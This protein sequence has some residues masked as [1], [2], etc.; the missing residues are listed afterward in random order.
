MLDLCP[1]PHTYTHTA[2]LLSAICLN[3]HITQIAEGGKGPDM[4]FLSLHLKKR[5]KKN[6]S[7]ILQWSARSGTKILLS[8]LLSNLCHD[9]D[10][11][12]IY[13][14]LLLFQASKT[15]QMWE[16]GHSL[17]TSVILWHFSRRSIITSSTAPWEKTSKCSKSCSCDPGVVV[18]LVQV[19]SAKVGASPPETS[20]TN[21]GGPSICLR[22]GHIVSRPPQACFTW[23][24]RGGP[25]ADFSCQHSLLNGLRC[26]HWALMGK[27]KSDCVY[28]GAR[29]WELA[30]R[31]CVCR[32]S[33][34]MWHQPI[35][36]C[37]SVSQRLK[38]N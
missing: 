21:S 15:V 19:R 28:S 22:M 38:H 6:I 31:V 12:S 17:L 7:N 10:F 5:N 35:M 32:W 34:E 9:T 3:T 13:T 18:F 1:H 4:D 26:R 23:D 29:Y 33:W 2:W 37:P 27:S 16:M 20:G 30:R 24:L 25:I 36:H 8:F 14:L 11:P